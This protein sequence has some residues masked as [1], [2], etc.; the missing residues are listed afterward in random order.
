MKTILKT[1]A[2]AFTLQALVVNATEVTGP[3]FD[4]M[5]K[6]MQYG[7]FIGEAVACKVTAETYK[8]KILPVFLKMVNDIVSRGLL[9]DD[10]ARESIQ[11]GIDYG[12]QT[13]IA[14]LGKSTCSEIDAYLESH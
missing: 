9:T 4:A 11:S 2:L 10:E 12:K 13:Q 6:L 7:T 5:T 1:I 14:G 3:S 8:E